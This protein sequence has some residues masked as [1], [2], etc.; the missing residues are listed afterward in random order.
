MCC[1]LEVDL[2]Q[3][4]VE[5]LPS[6]CVRLTLEYLPTFLQGTPL[7]EFE[8]PSFHPNK[9]VTRLD[10][11]Y[12]ISHKDNSVCL[13]TERFARVS[14]FSSE[15]FPGLRDLSVYQDSLYILGRDQLFITNLITLSTTALSLINTAYLSNAQAN[16]FHTM[17]VDSTAVFLTVCGRRRTRHDILRCTHAGKWLPSFGHEQKG[18]GLGECCFPSGMHSDNQWLYVA[19]TC[20]HRIQLFE[21]S[22]GKL[23]KVWSPKTIFCRPRVV[24]YFDSMVYIGDNT[25]VQCFSYDGDF[26]MRFGEVCAPSTEPSDAVQLVS[27]ITRMGAHLYVVSRQRIQMYS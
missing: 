21:K 22:L 10:S 20:N 13:L 4:I 25:G 19:D 11:L 17:H 1:K 26:L 2:N 8:K 18:N 14:S 27:G 5:S 6:V 3:E 7:N 12:T 15:H 23:S 9:L 24:F 16:W